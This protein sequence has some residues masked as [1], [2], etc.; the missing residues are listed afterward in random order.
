MSDLILCNLKQVID[1][2]ISLST[3]TLVDAY[4]LYPPLNDYYYASTD[5]DIEGTFLHKPTELILTSIVTETDENQQNYYYATLRSQIEYYYNVN[6]THSTDSTIRLER[7]GITSLDETRSTYLGL[8]IHVDTNDIKAAIVVKP[9]TNNNDDFTEKTI[10][11]IIGKQLTSDTYRYLYLLTTDNKIL[12]IDATNFSVS[13]IKQLSVDINRIRIVRDV[14]TH[15]LL[16]CTNNT[17][18]VIDN[19]GNKIFDKQ[20]SFSDNDTIKDAIL[21]KNYMVL[22]TSANKIVSCNRINGSI[23]SK[24]VVPS[25]IVYNGITYNLLSTNLH[26]VKKDLLYFSCTYQFNS[27]GVM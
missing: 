8:N 13:W 21:S 23:V 1:E 3:V 20:Y 22:L 26:D 12:K 18:V 5:Y 27:G 2:N 4:T 11:G 10:N 9:T 17:I 6:L 24:R 19:T 16:I 14:P 15:L 25:T 7:F